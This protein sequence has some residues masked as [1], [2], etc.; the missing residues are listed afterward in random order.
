MRV[1]EMFVAGLGAL[2]GL[3][4]A[5]DG[6]ATRQRASNPVRSYRLVDL[7][8]AD[9][10]NQG[11][12][13]M[14]PIDPDLHLREAPIGFSEAEPR[15]E[16]CLHRIA[17]RRLPE[18]RSAALCLMEVAADTCAGGDDPWCIDAL[19][20]SA[21]DVI[22]RAGEQLAASL[23]PGPLPLATYRSLDQLR[24]D[25]HAEF[26]GRTVYQDAM[27]RME[28]E[29]GDLT[30][31]DLQ[32]QRAPLTVGNVLQ[33]LR[34]SDSGSGSGERVGASSMERFDWAA[35]ATGLQLGD[36]LESI[37]REVINARPEHYR[38]SLGE[39]LSQWVQRNFASDAA[40][41]ITA[42]QRRHLVGLMLEGINARVTAGTTGDP[43]AAG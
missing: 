34:D 18:A 37:G 26:R 20:R 29:F 7:P 33:V 16:S 19:L 10:C 21:T 30:G 4:H 11:G 39:E 23:E 36:L 25:I 3:Q 12:H 35:R 27:Q 28:I 13:W 14:A 6:H 8:I 15:F 9:I 24:R 22:P 38:E 31:L 17:S 32:A 41:P 40:E 42:H 5:T 1:A 43:D 2:A